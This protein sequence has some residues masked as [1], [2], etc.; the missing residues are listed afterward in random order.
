MLSQAVAQDLLRE[1]QR[2]SEKAYAPFSHFNV[3]A[4]LLLKDGRVIQGSNIENASYGLTIC[5]ERVALF[6]AVSE[7]ERDFQALAVWAA[8]NAHG[9]VTPCGACRQV[10]AAFF[11]AE[12][13][14][15]YNDAQGILQHRSLGDLLPEAF[16]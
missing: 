14:I 12:T 6:K 3:G 10:M 11:A 2:A 15:I 1:A 4:A 16:G 7:G 9:H 5:A 8:A 13:P